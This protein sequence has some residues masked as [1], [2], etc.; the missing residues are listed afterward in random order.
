MIFFV[1]DNFIYYDIT[2]TEVIHKYKKAHAY[3]HIDEYNYT[4]KSNKQIQY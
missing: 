2:W 4:N 1:V 3:I